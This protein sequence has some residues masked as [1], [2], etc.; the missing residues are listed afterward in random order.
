MVSRA[1]QFDF[2][3]FTGLVACGGKSSRMGRDKSLL[4]YQE[5]PEVFRL[6]HLLE[7]HCKQV[8]VSCNGTQ[9]A[10]MFD[11]CKTLT[12]LPGLTACGPMAG[13]LTAY[14]YIPGHHFI[15]IGCDYPYLHQAELE[16]FTS[17]VSIE[18]S[19]AAFYNV[20]ENLY[21]PLLA[22]YP[23]TAC[24][25]LTEMYNSNQFSLQQFLQENEARKYVPADE[26][27]MTSADS[28]A[29]YLKAKMYLTTAETIKK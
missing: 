16:R 2:T 9:S 3:G 25:R 7:K 26:K 24:N 4:I 28:H 12:D 18:N 27:C 19:P 15:F 29:D 20:H 10:A 1:K 11:H 6:Y 5:K 14:H 13:L 21:E 22:Y 8:F 23:A 17:F